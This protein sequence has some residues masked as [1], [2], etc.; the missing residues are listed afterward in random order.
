MSK[1]D[2]CFVCPLPECREKSPGCAFF[3]ESDRKRKLIHGRKYI[4]KNRDKINKQ[5]RERA[6]KNRDASRWSAK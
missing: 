1:S 3:S 2:V 6:S 5:S 4:A